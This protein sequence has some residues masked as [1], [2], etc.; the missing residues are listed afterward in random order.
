M[1]VHIDFSVMTADGQAI[2]N[3]EGQ[4]DFEVLPAL[5]DTVSFLF[6]PK[7]VLPPENSGLIG[8]IKVVDRVFRPNPKFDAVILMLSDL[9]VGTR[10]Q[11]LTLMNYFEAGFGLFANIYNE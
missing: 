2:G 10:G 9:V 5:G 4:L 3:I 1:R 8:S 11:A 6:S 7:G